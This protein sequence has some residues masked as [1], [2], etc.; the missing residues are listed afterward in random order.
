MN[1]AYTVGE[2]LVYFALDL[3]FCFVIFSQFIY[4]AA[5]APVLFF[6]FLFKM[7]REVRLPNASQEMFL[8]GFMEGD[9]VPL[10]VN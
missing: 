6:C 9:Q 2:L 8:N 7:L 5:F 10:L 1:L 4:Y 3:G